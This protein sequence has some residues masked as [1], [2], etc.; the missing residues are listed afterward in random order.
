[1]NVT[2]LRIAFM[3]TP[4]F[5]VPFLQQLVADGYRIVGVY[6]Q[7]DRPAGRSGAPAPSPVKRAALQHNLP[8]Y[9]PRSLRRPEEQQRLRRDLAPDIIIL[10]A[11]GLILPQAVLDIPRY[12]GLN[13][14][15]SLLPRHRGPA[16]VVGALLAGDAET[17]VSM[18]LMDAGMDTGMVL[19]QRRIPIMPDDTT[20]TLTARLID[21]G[22]GLLSQTIPLWVGG[23]ITP[24]PQDDSKATYTKLLTKEDGV[25]DWSLSAVEIERRVRA[26]Q[27]WPGSYTTWKGRQIKVL[28]AEA[29]PDT[30]TPGEPG[31]VVPVSGEPLAA[32]VQTGSGLLQL[33]RVQL[34]GRRAMSTDEFLRGSRDFVGS[35][36]GGKRPL[37]YA[38]GRPEKPP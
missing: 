1:M 32:A 15:P 7:P 36:L 26:Y 19:A 2:G 16:P 11:Y 9:Q 17:G 34:E 30:G 10:A 23:D 4:D 33:L 29:L 35:R 18:M 38:L 3:G 31:R 8:V 27:P 14:H 25:I 22:R 5:A 21:L 6:T 12:G 28:E 20:P 13:V 37:D 24:Q